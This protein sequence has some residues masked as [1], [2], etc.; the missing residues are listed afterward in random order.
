MNYYIVHASTNTFTNA[1]GA[2][3]AYSSMIIGITNVGAIAISFVH[4]RLS[5]GEIARAAFPRDSME[6]LRR[7]V[8]LSSFLGIVGNVTHALAIAKGS[9][10]LAILGRFITGFSF[11]EIIQRQVAGTCLPAFLVAESKQ[12]AK[13]QEDV[14]QDSM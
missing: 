10:P 13:V 14:T 8:I 2:H 11:M 1:V 12:L 7:G 6:F 4:V 9:I 3:S 5:S